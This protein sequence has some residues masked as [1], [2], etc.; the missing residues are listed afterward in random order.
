VQ[1]GIA[2]EFKGLKPVA[3]ASFA[4]VSGGVHVGTGGGSFGVTVG[5]VA[6]TNRSRP[7]SIDT[8]FSGWSTQW[9]GGVA[10]GPGVGF[11]FGQTYPSGALTVNASVGAGIGADA[12]RETGYTWIGKTETVSG[13]RDLPRAIIDVLRPP[14]SSA[15]RP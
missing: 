7:A 11:S 9:T 3:V 5:I 4:Q 6:N 1:A 8:D 15:A 13:W 12:G 14:S 10:K 2:I